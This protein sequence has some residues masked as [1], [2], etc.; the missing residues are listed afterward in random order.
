MSQIIIL[1]A[2]SSYGVLRVFADQLAA[3]LQA[4]GKTVCVV[5]FF[6]KDWVER[7]RE[8]LGEPCEFVFSYNALG[9][10]LKF[11]DNT[12]LFNKFNIPCVAAMVDHPH[13]HVGRLSVP[14]HQLLVTCVDPSHFEFLR[15][16]FPQDRFQGMAFWSHSGTVGS[17]AKTKLV[18]RDISILFGSVAADRPVRQWDQTIPAVY[19]GLMNDMVDYALANECPPLETML[20]EVCKG[21]GMELCS[22][23]KRKIMHML[24]HVD[25]YIRAWQKYQ[26]IKTLVAAGL[27]VD[28]C[29]PYW[30]TSS[31]AD[32]LQIHPKAEFKE[33]LALIGRAKISI[34]A[35]ANFAA[36][37]HERVA[38]AM[39]NGAVAVTN[40]SEYYNKYYHND[41]DII[42][43][44]W[45]E[46]D[47]LPVRLVQLLSQPERLAAVAEAG[48]N[49]A[50]QVASW[51]QQAARLCELAAMTFAWRSI[52][53]IADC[54]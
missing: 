33:M 42:M 51:E 14:L 36:G 46:L 34:N 26:L 48:R 41:E 28:V 32:K 43:F 35:N 54:Q 2:G 50:R 38:N 6:Q 7:L 21:R 1:K 19:H 25:S 37:S 16:V 52:P 27:Q 24:C 29:G 11:D 22:G 10:D 20:A 31:L 13:Y 47:K 12:L 23:A 39:L 5:D 45:Q 3:S 9:L 40:Q 17:A 53:A 18:D 8:A 30:E 49:R 44:S 4:M 15:T